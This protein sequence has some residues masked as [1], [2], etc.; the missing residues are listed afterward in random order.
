MDEDAPKILTLQAEGCVRDPNG[1]HLKVATTISN[2][3][4]HSRS[5]VTITQVDAQREADAK[6]PLALLALDATHA[7]RLRIL[8]EGPDAR[9]TMAALEPHFTLQAPTE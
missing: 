5:K 9:E 6:S 1:L 8:V 4:R 3:C 2:L 7:R